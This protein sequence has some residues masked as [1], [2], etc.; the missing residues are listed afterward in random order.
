MFSRYEFHFRS[1]QIGL[2]A[3]VALFL[4]GGATVAN[5]QG[6][7]VEGTVLDTENGEPLPGVNVV[8]VGTQRGTTTNADGTF[9]IAVSAEDAR[10][11]F[12]FVGYESQTVPLDGRTELTIELQSSAKQLEGVVVTAL[13]IE[14]QQRSIGYSVSKVSGED[15]AEV[16]SSNFGDALTGK[17]AGVDVSGTATGPAGSSNVLI[18]GISSLTGDN[19]PL[20]VVDGVPLD[21]SNLAGA[22][23]WG[24]SDMGDGLTSI[25]PQDISEVSVL[26][27]ASAAALYGERASNGVVLISTK[28]GS[29]GGLGVE[30]SST[31]TVESPLNYFNSFQNEYGHGQ[32]QQEGTEQSWQGVVPTSQSQARSFGLSSWGPRMNEVNSAIE[33]DGEERSYSPATNNLSD[34]YRTGLNSSN[35]IALNG[36][37][38]S[39]SFRLSMSH[40]RDNAIVPNS[41]YDRTTM[42]V[43]ASSDFGLPGL[44]ADAKANYVRENAHNRPRVSDAPGNANYVVTLMPRSMDVGILAP[45]WVGDDRFD[46]EAVTSSA[47]NTNP[48]WAV[49][50]FSNEDQD[51][52]INGFVQLQYEIGDWVTLQG[53][54]EMDKYWTNRV[55]I[56]PYGTNYIPGGSFNETEYNVSEQNY[57]LQAFTTQNITPNL[58]LSARL[59]GQLRQNRNK[60]LGQSGTNFNIPGLQT[61]GNTSNQSPVFNFSE[62]EVWSAYGTADLAYKDYLFLNLSGRN[63]IASTLPVANNSYFY[64][65][66]SGSFVF[67]EAFELPDW[68]SFGKVRTGWAAVGGDTNPYQLNLTYQLTGHS[69]TNPNGSS[70]PVGEIAT[71]SVPNAALQ[72]S[73]KESIEG[74][75]ELGLFS[76]RVGLDFTWYREIT[77]NDI[78]PTTIPGA[79]G[80]NSR[81]LNVGETR[82]TGIEV[83]LRTTPAQLGDFEWNLDFNFSANNNEVVRITEDL[84]QLELGQPRTQSAFVRAREGEPYGAIMAYKFKRDEQGRLV[85][86]ASGLPQRRDSLNVAGHFPPDWRGGISNSFSYKGLVLRA[87]LDVQIG[88]SVYSGTNTIATSSGLHEQTLEGREQG[89]VEVEG[90]DENGNET[91]ARVNPQTYWGR[92]SEISNEFVYDASYVKL[93]ELR[94]GYRFSSLIEQ[95]PI[96]TASI[97]V[98]ARNLWILHKNIPN[99]DPESTYNRS[100][101]LQ[102]LEYFGVPQTRNLGVSLNLRF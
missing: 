61:I 9:E 17:I 52:R 68:V 15:L 63:D 95:L 39:T 29:S 41:D 73:R 42:L 54:T 91:T 65:S 13:G 46:E 75:L 43:R 94:L 89:Y 33:F 3:A 38:E 71:G 7:T 31:T 96:Q 62:S 28:T 2:F 25:N 23:M 12:S 85:L 4:I 87:M 64:P 84:N 6:L 48:Y 27:G 36:G 101:Q 32:M 67:S 21:N 11:R 34:F 86:D 72:P 30:F 58:E 57:S 24:G 5:A 81:V 69:H 88:G 22:S 77:T 35:S 56:E 76:E 102:G 74:G 10:L 37:T 99:V 92:Y 47:F 66:V 44:S 83:A 40:R 78:V 59:G 16:P 53:R 80:Y 14:R 49:N 60:T 26:K 100:T 98:T 93:R 79:S 55:T 18:R 1:L 51:D 8:E 19:Q 82:N 97:A 50:R 70:V 20:Y 90:V 45:G